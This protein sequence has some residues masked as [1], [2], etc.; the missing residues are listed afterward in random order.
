MKSWEKFRKNIGPECR[1]AL[2]NELKEEFGDERNN[3]LDE[4]LKIVESNSEESLM[5]NEKIGK[6][7]ED[8]KPSIYKNIHIFIHDDGKRKVIRD[9]G[10]S[11][12]AYNIN[13]TPPESQNDDDDDDDDQQPQQ[14][15]TDNLP[16]CVKQFDLFK[17]KLKWWFYHK[18]E[19]LNDW[20]KVCDEKDFDEKRF[21]S[22]NKHWINKNKLAYELETLFNKFFDSTYTSDD[23]GENRNKVKDHLEK[24]KR[25][26]NTNKDV[27]EI[28][29]LKYFDLKY[30]DINDL[31][32]QIEEF[33]SKVY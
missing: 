1:E 29:E 24:A 22:E 16:E 15:N 32:E 18:N 26:F 4:L 21:H 19:Y 3:A 33:C 7:L 5:A 6:L 2:Y 10:M 17:T 9:I 30:I 25:L 28:S 11:I 20:V 8:I 13:K 14:Q 23:W 27:S 12:Y 31:Y